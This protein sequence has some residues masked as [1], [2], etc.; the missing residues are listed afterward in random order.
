MEELTA[1]LHQVRGGGARYVDEPSS[2][3]G[4][5]GPQ[6]RQGDGRSSEIIDYDSD[7]DEGES[8]YDF[9]GDGDGEA[10]EVEEQEDMMKREE[11]L[12]AELNLATRRCQELKDTLQVTKSFL[13]KGPN[14]GMKNQNDGTKIAAEVIQSDDDEDETDSDDD[15]VPEEYDEDE[16]NSWDQQPRTGSSVST[17]STP[18]ETSREAR[19]R[20]RQQQEYKRTESST[21]DDFRVGSRVEARYKGG[22]KYYP[23][24]ISRVRLDGS[25][26]VEYDDGECESRIGKLLIRLAASRAV[27]GGAQ[28]A[29]YKRAESNADP[30]ETPRETPRMQRPT[31]IAVKQSRYHYKHPLLSSSRCTVKQP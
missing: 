14:L 7:S 16:D 31:P 12:Q 21:T 25:F 6:D 27:G 17:H 10:D 3:Q 13:G 22:A 18:R 9:G 5:R 26:D 24:K 28:G 30:Y 2:G 23:G 29:V 20:E 19:E 11:E 15:D 4:G 8:S 1:K